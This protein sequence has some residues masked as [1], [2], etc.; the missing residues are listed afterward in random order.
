MNDDP[1]ARAA[2]GRRALLRAGV[3]AALAL[4]ARPALALVPAARRLR[5]L[6]AHTGERLDVTYAEGGEVLPKALAEVDRFLRDFRTGEVHAMDPRV[7]DVLWALARA[8]GRPLG[9]FEIVSGYRSPWTNAMLH[10]RSAG[11]AVHSLHLEGKAIDL[12]LPGVPTSDLRAL[13][14]GLRRGGVGYYP[15]ADFVHVDTGRVRRW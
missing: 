12:R 6:H 8:A 3:G 9:T 13:A 14:L 10:E 5:M 1:S 15:A 4:A 11:V 7:L 2:L